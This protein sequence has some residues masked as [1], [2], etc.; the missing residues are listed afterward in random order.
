VTV[1]E[2]DRA[3]AKCDRTLDGHR[4]AEVWTEAWAATQLELW[5]TRDMYVRMRD[6]ALRQDAPGGGE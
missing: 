1:A 6:A 5:R 4:S 3:I 2:L